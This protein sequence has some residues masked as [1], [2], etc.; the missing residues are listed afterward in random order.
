[1]KLLTSAALCLSISFTAYS[2]LAEETTNH[3]FNNSCDVALQ[4]SVRIEKNSIE[5]LKDEK[6][7]YKIINDQELII[8]NQ[9]VDLNNKQQALVN[10]YAVSIR[11]TVPKVK[12]IA[13]NAID[14]ATEGVTLALNELLGENNT[15]VKNLTTEL[16]QVRSEVNHYFTDN[17]S[18]YFDEN[19][20]KGHD[21]LSND[22]EQRIEALVEE[23]VQS[24]IGNLLVAIGQE[25][26]T[27][28]GDMKAFE[29]KME[30]FGERIE[31][32]MEL[33]ASTL[34]TEADSL[35]KSVAQ[36]DNLEEQLK[37]AV[38]M[39]NQTNVLTVKLQQSE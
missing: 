19:G 1:M 13:L 17:K 37:N 9:K 32:E 27:S 18:I 11:N 25:M 26:L 36:I 4:G 12:N 38:P 22:F 16:T 5:F 21:F 30:K 24:S 3:H 10:D 8:N 28:G 7:Q 2:S 31:N 39:L 6:S 33:K 15:A 23:T 14:L 34:E 20:V 35:C 29:A